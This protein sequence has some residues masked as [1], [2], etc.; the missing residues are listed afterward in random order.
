MGPTLFGSNR[1]ASASPHAVLHA[2][3]PSPH[4]LASAADANTTGSSRAS[5]AGSTSSAG[6]LES[7]RST[8]DVT[9]LQQTSLEYSRSAD[10]RYV[11]SRFLWKPAW[12]SRGMIEVRDVISVVAEFMLASQLGSLEV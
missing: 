6:S 10:G 2:G 3:T 9:H 12:L 7:S 11:N 4:G 1:L 8:D 5:R